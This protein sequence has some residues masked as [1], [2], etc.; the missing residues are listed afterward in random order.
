[1]GGGTLPSGAQGATVSGFVLERCQIVPGDVKTVFGFF[2]DPH[3]LEAITPPWLHFHVASSSTPVVRMGTEIH[4]RLRWQVVPLRWSS[5][6]SEYVEG[7][8]FADEMLRGPY[9]RWYHRHFFTAVPSGVE[10]RD[11]VQYQLPFGPVGRV[12]HAMTVRSQLEAIFDYR[13][14]TITEIFGLPLPAGTR[15][16]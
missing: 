8:L 6:I 5:R 16:C 15:S 10:V 14:N 2:K 3:N 9:R 4:Y 1:M 13:Q 7:E 11:V 12:V